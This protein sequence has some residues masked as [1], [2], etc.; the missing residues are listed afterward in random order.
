[1]I[2]GCQPK[3]RCPGVDRCPGRV[4]LAAA[5]DNDDPAVRIRVTQTLARIGKPAVA[6]LA[7][8][9][10]APEPNVRFA[11][12]TGLAACGPEGLP[13]LLEATNDTDPVLRQEAARLLVVRRPPLNRK[14]YPPWC[15]YSRT[16]A[17][18]SARRPLPVCEPFVPNR[19]WWCRC[20]SRCWP[21]P[22][23]SFA[24]MHCGVRPTSGRR[25]ADPGGR[26]ATAMPT[27]ARPVRS[28][29]PKCGPR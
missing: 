5:R 21:T 15:H 14:W 16:R 2:T 3:W 24:S 26:D 28:C 27:I 23:T 19:P 25:R 18:W 11:A 4:P 7:K 8:T 12:L 17:N 20:S 6:V 9:S 29:L 22:P 10:K 13:G 1:M